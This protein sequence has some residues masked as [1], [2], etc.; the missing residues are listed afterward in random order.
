M[1]FRSSDDKAAYLGIYMEDVTATIS[2]A[3]H[4]P[5]G[6]FVKEVIKD[7]PAEK[8]G[9]KAGDIITSIDGRKVGTRE[10]L[11]KRLRY[12]EAGTQAELMIQRQTQNGYQEQKLTVV[13]A[14]KES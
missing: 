11:A 9:L 12:Y 6:V 14:K 8:Y 2:E 13:L 4:M 10:E 1:L 7:T 3:Y 5:E